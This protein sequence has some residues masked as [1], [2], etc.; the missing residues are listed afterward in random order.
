MLNGPRAYLAKKIAPR[1]QKAAGDVA[2]S[3]TAFFG[4]SWLVNALAFGTTRNNFER[5]TGINYSCIEAHA[6]AIA[7][8]TWKVYR[9]DTKQQ[10]GRDEAPINDPWVTLKNRPNPT[11]PW[12][13][14]DNILKG[15]DQWHSLKGI[16][17]LYGPNPKKGTVPDHLWLLPPDSVRPYGENGEIFSGFKLYTPRG[18]VKLGKEELCWIPLMSPQSGVIE[19]YFN[20]RSRTDAAID[21]VDIGYFSRRYLKNFYG[22]NAIP[23]MVIETQQQLY[24]KDIKSFLASFL[25]KYQGDSKSSEP[26]ILP[27]SARAVLLDTTSN[28]KN[29]LAVAQDVVK[30]V[31][32][33]YRVPMGILTGEFDSGAPAT[34]YRAQTFTFYQ[35][36]IGPCAKYIGTVLTQWAQMRDS[37]VIIDHE[38]IE[39]SD[40]IEVRADEVHRLSTGQSTIDDIRQENGLQPAPAG[41]GNVLWFNPMLQPIEAIL[42]NMPPQP[43]PIASV[44]GAD[45]EDAEIVPDPLQLTGGVARRALK[46]VGRIEAVRVAYWKGWDDQR[47]TYAKLLKR[48][49]QQGLRDIERE[50]LAGI[51]SAKAMKKDE[52]FDAEAAAAR[53]AELTAEDRAKLVDWSVRT[54]F[55]DADTNPTD[56]PDEF[57]AAVSASID[58][59]T[60]LIREPAATIKGEMQSLLRTMK[61]EKPAVIRDAIVARFETYSVGRADVIAKTT[62]AVTINASQKHAWA[63]LGVGRLWLTRRDG[64]VRVAHM[65]DGQ[66]ANDQGLFA[67]GDGRTVPYP[68]DPHERCIQ[69]PDTL[70]FN[71]QAG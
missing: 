13:T 34:S 30:S 23:D 43:P 18:Y 67:L 44:R 3:S 37:T 25:E 11:F 60:E 26:A 17:V 58:A 20:G 33:I 8:R 45:I 1:S 66:K 35:N 46:S 47:A 24:E 71:P 10:D 51:D 69:M 6:Q 27:P 63:G 52:T 15:I 68:S 40:P 9:A 53:L 32:M 22:R 55:S 48:Q 54:A 64:K 41:I 70:K 5:F 36:E 16:A 61:D 14:W 65:I 57:T 19:Y 62:A 42:A 56:H 39:W 4:G 49:V 31:A 29:M 28:Q 12:V 7:A 38:P 21:E 50:I 59:S 2:Q